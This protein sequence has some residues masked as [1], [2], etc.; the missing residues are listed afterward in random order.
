[1]TL[2]DIKLK[3]SY[4]SDEDDILNSFYIPTLSESVVYKRIA[5][6]FSSVSLAIA[7]KG[8]A[9]FIFNGGKFQ[10]ITNVV[11]SKEDYNEIKKFVDYDFI[12]KIEQQ[13]IENLQDLEEGLIKDHVKMLGWLLKNGKLDMKIAVINEGTGLHHQKTGIL[14]DKDGNVISF[15]G[16]D[17][18][19]KAGWI[20]NIEEFHLF[21]NW[22]E[23]DLK[24]IQSDQKRFDKFW[25]NNANRAFVFSL[26]DAVKK[27]LIRISPKSEIEFENL[28]T[29]IREKMLNNLKLPE[30]DKTNQK[31][32]K[33]RKYQN[34]AI[35]SWFNAGKKGIIEMATGTGKTFV[36][37]ECLKK[38]IEDDNKLVTVIVVPTIHLISQWMDDV[39]KIKLDDILKVFGSQ[40]SWGNKLKEK[41]DNFNLGYIDNLVLIT[42]YDTMCSEK[43]IDIINNIDNKK[44]FLIADE[45]HSI[46]SPKRCKALLN[47]YTYRLGLS[48]TPERWFDECGTNIINNFFGSV[49]FRYTLK[50][51]I[52]E[53]YLS[54]YEYYPIF[55]ELDDSEFMNYVKLTKKISQL[56]HII[57]DKE[58]R[59]DVL[60]RFLIK[61]RNILKNAKGKITSFDTLIKNLSNQSE[62]SHCLVY[63]SSS[64]PDQLKSVQKIINKYDILQHKFTS[65][66]SYSERQKILNLLKEGKYKILLA[67]RC[68]DEGVNIPS[69]S[70]AI[71]L[72][73][74]TN[75]RQFIQR[76]GRILRK[77][78]GKKAVIYDFIIIPTLEPNTKSQYFELEKKIIEKELNRYWEF[79]SS[80]TNSAEAYKKIKKVREEYNI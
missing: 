46:G 69:I 60:S 56:Y 63:C 9:N 48:A 16:S 71:I 5:G 11:L 32:F 74:T 28:T 4:D 34:E 45:V 75:P 2:K 76:R 31:E 79:A 77:V 1:M 58:K 44:V 23:G 20:D 17:N 37:L 25:N 54:K 24:H 65:K 3:S 10:L 66:E 49:I 21:R 30:G 72:S 36:A 41:I 29:E 15:S 80:A 13:F 26:S 70:T 27:Q 14:E 50:E 6:F 67:M 55:I 64:S 73:S 52:S 47:K 18:E 68:L 59:S 39:K 38:L 8:L 22:E 57:K 40:Y 53:G 78:I 61:R 12:E 19:T 7:A 51:A 42:T 43:F 33:L 62:I 35:T